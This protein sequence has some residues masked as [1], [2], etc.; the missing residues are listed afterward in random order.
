MVSEFPGNIHI[1]TLCPK[2]LQSF[3]KFLAAVTED[4]PLKSTYSIVNRWPKI[5][6]LKEPNFLLQI[7]ES[8]FPGNM[9]FYTMCIL[10]TY[11]D[12]RNSKQRF[13][14]NF[15]YRNRTNWLTNCRTNWLTDGQVKQFA[16]RNFV[17]WVLKNI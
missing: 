12:L 4:L 15:A 6:S 9:L 8:G 10:N 14:R 7:R 2:Y 13:K 1:H 16:P 17:E 5:L 11:R 3:T